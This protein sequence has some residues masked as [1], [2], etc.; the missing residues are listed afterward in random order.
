MP[1]LIGEEVLLREKVGWHGQVLTHVMRR[2]HPVHL[3]R[4]EDGK[5]KGVGR[6]TGRRDNGAGGQ[7]LADNL[8][9]IVPD[10]QDD[11]GAAR[12]RV[13]TNQRDLKQ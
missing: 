7:E 3:L 9:V 1:I 8:R 10:G 11:R 13:Y 5:E 4:V 6:E 12:C 2:G